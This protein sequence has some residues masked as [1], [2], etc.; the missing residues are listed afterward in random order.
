MKKDGEGGGGGC[1][2]VYY[3]KTVQCLK[4]LLELI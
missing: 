1:I 2:F 3:S 4:Q